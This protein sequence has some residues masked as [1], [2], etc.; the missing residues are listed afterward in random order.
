MKFN[1]MVQTV[2]FLTLHQPI[3]RWYRHRTAHWHSVSYM[4][5]IWD[6]GNVAKNERKYRF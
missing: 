4:L 1:L 3:C 5:L 2:A 6:S